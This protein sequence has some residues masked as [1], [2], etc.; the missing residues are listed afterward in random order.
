MALLLLRLQCATC[1]LSLVTDAQRE[2]LRAAATAAS[3][4]IDR[5][6]GIDD[7]LKRVEEMAEASR[8]AAGTSRSSCAGSSSSATL[9]AADAGAEGAPADVLAGLE[10]QME[11]LMSAQLH[12]KRLTSSTFLVWLH[13]VSVL[14]PMQMASW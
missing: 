8:S 13:C 10:Q 5:H 1:L 11:L 7:V 3:R 4:T 2:E 6:D 14:T 9:P 12:K